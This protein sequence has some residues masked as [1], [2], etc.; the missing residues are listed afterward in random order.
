MNTFETQITSLFK[1]YLRED[2]D[3]PL[4]E[5]PI[6]EMGFDSLDFFEFVMGV[7]DIIGA[8]LD[9]EKLDPHLTFEEFL[10]FCLKDVT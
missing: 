1:T 2:Y 3:A 7:E 4:S 10:V 9:V 6:A 5:K 8:E